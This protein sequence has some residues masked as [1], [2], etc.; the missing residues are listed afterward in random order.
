MH[1]LT[2][3][4]K[5]YCRTACTY[6]NNDPASRDPPATSDTE[7]SLAG[8]NFGYLYDEDVLVLSFKI[9]MRR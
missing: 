1:R 3:E 6:N 9:H 2:E 5:D 7:L 8:L 4:V